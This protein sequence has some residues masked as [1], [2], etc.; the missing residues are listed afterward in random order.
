MSILGEGARQIV[1]WVRSDPV[2]R[3]ASAGLGINAAMGTTSIAD[4]INATEDAAAKAL[5]VALLVR[6]LS[7]G[8]FGSRG[9][10]SGLGLDMLCASLRKPE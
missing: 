8:G 5:N 4:P 9:L 7:S 6:H 1:L 3:P 10:T 2:K